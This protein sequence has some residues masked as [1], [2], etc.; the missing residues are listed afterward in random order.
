MDNRKMLW[1]IFGVLLLICIA[2]WMIQP[3]RSDTPPPVKVPVTFD[4]TY[5]IESSNGASLTL[6]N[7]GG[8]TEQ[9][10][11]PSGVWTKK[12]V[13]RPGDFLYISA[14]S[15]S[16]SD[17]A[18]ITCKILVNGAEMKTSTSEGAYKIASCSLGLPR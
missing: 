3:P 14:Q 8:G 13:S 18:K 12:M 4:V 17:F 7:E 1:S 10:D 2:L 15:D 5:H 16:G 9:F 6:H 11:I